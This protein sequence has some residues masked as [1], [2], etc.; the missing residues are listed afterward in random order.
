[1]L[2]NSENKNIKGFISSN[3]HEIIQ[4]R[5]SLISYTML[6]YFYI[7]ILIEKWYN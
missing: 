2:R 1:M 6:I 3:L 5:N 4:K 7:Q